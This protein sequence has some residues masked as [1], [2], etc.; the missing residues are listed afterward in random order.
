MSNFLFCFFHSRYVFVVDAV[1]FIFQ[2]ID[3]SAAKVYPISTSSSSS[4]LSSGTR[5]VAT[6]SM[7]EFPDV[8][9]WKLAIDDDDKKKWKT[10]GF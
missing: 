1:K 8:K 7:K 5:E 4:N 6:R 3:M 9:K 2:P 10:N